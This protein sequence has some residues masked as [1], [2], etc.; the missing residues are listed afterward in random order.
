VSA[1][2]ATARQVRY[3]QLLF[4][5]SREAAIFV[6]LLPVLLFL[7]LA[8]VY[9]DEIDGYDAKTFLLVGMIGY[10]VAN[11]AF[12]GLAIFLV[13]RREEGILKRIRAT[14]LPAAAYLAAVLVSSL[15]V[16][17]LQ[18][19]TLVGVG[20]LLFDAE[21]PANV[22]GMLL[23]LGAGALAFAALGVGAAAVVRSSEGA[24]PIVNIVILPMAFLSGSFGS[25]EDY[26]PVL[27]A[28]GRVL[29]LRHFLELLG[30]AYLDGESVLSDPGSW[31]A[32]GV[33]ALVGVAVAWRFFGWQP[34]AR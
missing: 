7:L 17:A 33:W 19:A 14:P 31:A 4:W 1:L 28:I 18:V 9:D 11:T 3:E 6:F 15:L 30:A 13:L 34:R 23:V 22:A 27:E 8:S 2:V 29:P 16:F 20:L 26:P 10:G 12:G 24:S 25:P 32:L 21:G 5:R